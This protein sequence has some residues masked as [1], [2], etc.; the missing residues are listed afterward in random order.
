MNGLE[1][2][3][4]VG[5][6]VPLGVYIQLLASGLSTGS[7][8]AL[9]GL[10]LMLAYKGTGVL[11]FAQGEFVTLGAYV[12]LFFSLYFALPYWAFFVLDPRGRRHLRRALRAPADPSPDEGAGVHDRR[13]DTCGQPHDQGCAAESLA[14]R[15][16]RRFPRR[17]PT[18]RCSSA[19]SRSTRNISGSLPALLP[20]WACL[21]CFSPTISPAKQCAR[22]RKI[23][24]PRGSWAS[25]LTGSFP[26]PLRSA[27]QSRRWPAC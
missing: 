5:F 27:P 13:G 12:A 16:S 21:L 24:P 3:A 18:F 11:N 9:V 7:I 20:S 6:R 19:T 4:R 25:A 17:S 1:P 26:R 2:L 14:R 22:L 15:R 8:Y 10:G 23:R